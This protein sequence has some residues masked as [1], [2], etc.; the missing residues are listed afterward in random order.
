LLV[1]AVVAL[2]IFSAQNFSA[3]T[4]YVNMDDQSRNA[5]DLIS[6]EIRNASALINTNGSQTLVLTNATLAQSTT[7]NFNSSAGTLTLAKTGQPTKT[8]LTGCSTFNFSLFNR[9]PITNA[10][11]FYASTNSSGVGD[12]LFCKVINMNWKCTR[13]I[14]GMRTNLN[15]EVVQTAQVVLRNQV[16]H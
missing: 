4:N 5:L 13:S 14:G 12:V 10:Y 7:I 2:S 6:R 16:S 1:G 3:V 8:L 9:R 15:T 11:S